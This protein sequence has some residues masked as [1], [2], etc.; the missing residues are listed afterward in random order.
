MA[1]NLFI[2]DT[3]I[4]IITTL[5][6]VVFYNF[7]FGLFDISDGGVVYHNN[8]FDLFFHHDKKDF[9]IYRK[10]HIETYDVK[11]RSRIKM[12]KNNFREGVSFKII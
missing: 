8:V 12:Y 1:E 11:Y 10:R 7:F 2:C 4:T 9:N 3:C 5:R 6:S